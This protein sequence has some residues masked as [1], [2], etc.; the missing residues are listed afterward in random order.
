MIQGVCVKPLRDNC[1]S[2]KK[3]ADAGIFNPYQPAFTEV[4]KTNE[5]AVEILEHFKMRNYTTAKYV[6]TDLL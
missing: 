1:D 2:L 3:L 6:E 4:E 5:E